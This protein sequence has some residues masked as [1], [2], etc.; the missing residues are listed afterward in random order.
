LD[1]CTNTFQ[2]TTAFYK[3]KSPVFSVGFLDTFAHMSNQVY[4]CDN[5]IHVWDIDTGYVL[6]S[7]VPKSTEGSVTAIDI[8]ASKG[9]LAI[10][11]QAGLLR[12]WDLRTGR[13]S[14]PWFHAQTSAQGVSASVKCVCVN[15]RAQWIAT[16]LASG[17]VTIFDQR[18][19]VLFK[20]FKA[21]DGPVLSLTLVDATHILTTGV[22]RRICLWRVGGQEVLL[23]TKFS[24]VDP[25]R[26]VI[27]H[28]KEFL[29]AVGSRLGVGP[30][31]KKMSTLTRG[32]E[33]CKLTMTKLANST[34]PL[35]ANITCMSSLPQF[36]L[37]AVAYD[38][39]NL[40]FVE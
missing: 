31:K 27:L 3:H 20:S 34:V 8:D 21:H 6:H 19:G 26:S 2:Q 4:S 36:N 32:G 28:N 24:S 16:G 35:R 37:L 11:T 22:D 40:S 23:L 13:V 17:T 33:H 18:T 10:G 14:F 15:K 1:F 38:D 12:F 30:V 7:L 29:C 25:S 9:Y 39:G 5:S